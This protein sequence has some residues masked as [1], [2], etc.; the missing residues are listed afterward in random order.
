VGAVEVV[1]GEVVLEVFGERGQLRYERAGEAGAPAFLED[2]LLE[3]FDVAVRGWP[4][5]ADAAL[6]DVEPLERAGEGAGPKLGAVIGDHGLELPACLGELARDPLDQCRAVLG[7][8]VA[9]AGV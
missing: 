4:A 6:L 7:D 9:A 3:P 5:G 1:V 8:R 2:R